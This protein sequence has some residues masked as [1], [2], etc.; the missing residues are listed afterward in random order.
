V[1]VAGVPAKVAV[2]F[3]LLVKLSPRGIA[4]DMLKVGVGAPVATNV[5]APAT[6]TIKA[7]TLLEL[8]RVAA[9][10]T[11]SAGADPLPA[12]HPAKAH[13]SS[14]ESKRNPNIRLRARPRPVQEAGTHGHPEIVC[15]SIYLRPSNGQGRELDI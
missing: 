2:P 9:K 15:A 4:P 13:P 3:M 5:E 8:E 1:A 12:P 11:G 14:P 7:F 6:P 10:V